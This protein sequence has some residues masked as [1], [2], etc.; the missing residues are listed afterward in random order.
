MPANTDAYAPESVIGF[1]TSPANG[2]GTLMGCRYTVVSKSPV[3]DGWNDANSGGSFGPLLKGSGFDAVFI[4]GISPEP[5]YIFLDDGKIEIRDAVQFWGL[6]VEAAE[7]AIKE[8][9][10]DSKIG[11]ALIG[12]AGERKAMM[13][14]IMN[15]THRAAGRGGSG[16]VMGSKNL[17]AIVA[18]GKQRTEIFD[19]EAKVHFN[20]QIAEWQK[21]GPPSG[22]LETFKKQGTGSSYGSSVVGGDA[23]IKN[24]WGVGL[25]DIS[26]EDRYTVSAAGMDEKYKKKKFSCDTCPISCGA[27]YEI[28]D[29]KYPIKETGRPEYE[30]IG[31]FGCGLLNNDTVCINKCNHLCNDYGLDAISVG[32]TVMWAMDAY[33]A[34]L[35]S[36]ADID[37][38]N[39][40]WGDAD[41]IVAITEKIATGEGVGAVLQHGS[42]Y[43]ADY[44]GKGGDRLIVA[45]GIE[46]PMHDSRYAPG[47]ARTYKYDPTP[48]RH[49]KGGLGSPQ[50]AEPPEIKYSFEGTGDRD[51]AGV[52]SAETLSFGG[53]CKFTGFG[54]P[55]GTIIGLLNAVTGF[56]YSDEDAANLG[57]RSFIIRHAFNLRDGKLRDYWTLS[58]R[59]LG[60]PALDRGPMEG[61]TIDVEKLADSFYDSFGFERETGIPKVETLDAIGGLDFVKKDLYPEVSGKKQ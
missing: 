8:K 6:T 28:N 44:F 55:P 54:F 53:F 43:A 56:N 47:L 25:E 11:I 26:E 46:L 61:V 10:G 17:K 19:N 3:Y 59:M 57:K 32:G 30:T 1:L 35:L 12:P 16:A 36:A 14:A 41:A 18:R 45:S 40:K 9:I 38:I 33:N 58:E 50:G 5:V 20:K 60:Y 24:W 23:G 37:G 7:V 48:G 39:L 2:T 29:E 4:K 51:V 21:S 22:M 13:A 42:Q 31:L 52:I 15:D 27:I 34:S 49:T